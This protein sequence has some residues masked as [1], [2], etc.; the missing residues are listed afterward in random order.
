MEIILEIINGNHKVQ[1]IDTQVTV[2]S[3]PR[4]KWWYY[5]EEVVTP[6]EVWQHEQATKQARRAREKEELERKEALQWR[7]NRQRL[8]SPSGQKWV[9]KQYLAQKKE[10]LQEVN[11]LQPQH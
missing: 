10:E 3:P 7:R 5:R 8:V 2:T 9:L 4:K 1:Y 6:R 11:S